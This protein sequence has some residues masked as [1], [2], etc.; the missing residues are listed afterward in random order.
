MTERKIL[1]I[2][3]INL[4]VKGFS[5]FVC[6]LVGLFHLGTPTFLSFA[7]IPASFSH[8]GMASLGGHTCLTGFI[9][10]APQAKELVPN[11]QCVNVLVPD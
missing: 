8:T 3:V 1:F 10:V 7:N 11:I 5:F 4:L 9:L 6:L 2:I